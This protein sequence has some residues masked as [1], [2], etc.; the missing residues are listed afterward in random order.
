MNF[1]CSEVLILCYFIKRCHANRVKEKLRI[2][3][4]KMAT[5]PRR[6]LW[7]SLGFWRVWLDRSFLLNWPYFFNI[8]TWLNHI[9]ANCHFWCNMR[10]LG[11]KTLCNVVFSFEVGQTSFF[12]NFIVDFKIEKVWY[13]GFFPILFYIKF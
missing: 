11:K 5:F 10:R 8:E 2:F 12:H 13:H 7:K 3:M 4:E 6:K 9:V 1:F